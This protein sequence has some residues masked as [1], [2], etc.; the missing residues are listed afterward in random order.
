MHSAHYRSRCT[1]H[2]V[3]CTKYRHKI[4]KLKIRDELTKLIEDICTRNDY[5]LLDY[6]IELDHVHLCIALKPNVSV[7]SCIHKLKSSTGYHLRLMFPLTVKRYLWGTK[8]FWSRGYFVSTIGDV[9]TS[10]VLKYIQSQENYN[11]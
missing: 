11:A 5:K 2:I 3:I 8:R 7:S 10:T 4:L 9:S 6:S 1:F